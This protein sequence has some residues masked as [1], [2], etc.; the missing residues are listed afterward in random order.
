MAYPRKPKLHITQC[1]YFRGISLY[2][3][4]TKLYPL[5]IQKINTFVNGNICDHQYGIRHNRANILH[6]VNMIKI[7]TS[8]IQ[9]YKL[10]RRYLHFNLFQ[11]ILEMS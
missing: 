2:E 8:A 11:N 1:S 3:L 5:F 10:I 4:H 6:S 9:G 7:M